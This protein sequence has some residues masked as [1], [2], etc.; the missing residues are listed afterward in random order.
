MFL[1]LGFDSTKQKLP[2]FIL[3]YAFFLVQGQ[4]H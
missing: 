3:V 4:D 2:H 1:V